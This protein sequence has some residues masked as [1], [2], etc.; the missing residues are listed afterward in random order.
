MDLVTGGLVSDTCQWSLQSSP[1]SPTDLT[2]T[3]SNKASES[4]PSAYVATLLKDTTSS[5]LLETIL[6]HAPP[7]VFDGLWS[8]YLCPN[9]DAS[10]IA[11]HAVSNY[12]LAKAVTKASGTQLDAMGRGW[13]NKAVKTGRLGVVKAVVDRAVELKEGAEGLWEGVRDAF[14]VTE[15]AGAEETLNCVLSRKTLQVCTVHL[16]SSSSSLTPRRTSAQRTLRNRMCKVLCSCNHSY[17]S[18][19]PT[20]QRWSKTYFLSLSSQL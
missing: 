4:E 2:R 19:I 8:T 20:T 14:E 3:V 16:R 5:H 1:T 17:D 15:E 18:P 13:W 9:G 12:V 6:L 11:V 7:P 10:K